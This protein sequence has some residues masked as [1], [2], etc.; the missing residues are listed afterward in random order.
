MP[1]ND[2]QNTEEQ[3]AG[4]LKGQFALQKIYLKDM[5][6]ET[7]NSP[8]VF[9]EQWNLTVNMDIQNT[10]NKLVD[11]NYEVVIAV[12]VT[13]KFNDQTVY[14]I[15]AHQAGIFHITGFPD[16]ILRRTLTTVCPNILFPFAREVVSDLVTRGGFPQLLLAPV[17]FEALYQQHQEELKNT[18]E[19]AVKH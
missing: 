3:G 9:Q 15:E 13:V 2:V 10:V 11:D 16:D 7:P 6:F 8:Q 17:N 5:S 19:S 4:E 18:E 1:D 14:L 12:T